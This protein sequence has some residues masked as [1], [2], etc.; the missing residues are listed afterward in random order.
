MH[1]RANITG[2]SVDAGIETWGKRLELLA[3]A[4]PK[5]VN[6]LFV[7]TQGGLDA[8][9]GRA[10]REAAQKLGITLVSAIVNSPYDE[11]EYRRTFSSIQ[12]D[13]LDG[14]VLSES[15]NWTV[16]VSAVLASNRR[17]ELKAPIVIEPNQ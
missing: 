13:Q 1:T 3:E 4:V 5:L 16:A 8:A 11:A 7:S 2:V 9:G 17:L 6:V 14:I 12:K 10:V 15:G